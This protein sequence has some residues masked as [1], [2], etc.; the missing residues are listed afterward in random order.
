MVTPKISQN[1]P[2]GNNTKFMNLEH[3]YLYSI[4]WNTFMF[5]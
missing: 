1:F 5:S 2:N 4:V 3:D